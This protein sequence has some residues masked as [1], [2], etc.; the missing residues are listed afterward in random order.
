V[1]PREQPSRSRRLGCTV[2]RPATGRVPGG[3]CV[4]MEPRAACALAVHP[5][6]NSI[7]RPLS[8]GHA[9]ARTRAFLAGAALEQKKLP[10]ARTAPCALRAP[11]QSASRPIRT[12]GWTPVRP[13]EQA[14]EPR[15]R[16]CGGCGMPRPQLMINAHGWS[17][18]PRRDRPPARANCRRHR[19]FGPPAG[20]RGRSGRG[21]VERV[22]Y[23]HRAGRDG[24]AG[25]AAADLDWQAGVA[26]GA[27]LDV[28]WAMAGAR[29]CGLR[30]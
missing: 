3:T 22:G 26:K 13:L 10:P 4:T 30:R 23:P 1:K 16:H 5:V 20:C 17:P 21:A 2:S 15:T 9:V 11:T 6:T 29:R 8:R 27:M 19:R 14:G 24:D 7:D 12:G 18:R 28:G 25:G